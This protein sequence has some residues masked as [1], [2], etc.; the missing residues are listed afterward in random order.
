MGKQCTQIQ[1]KLFFCLFNVTQIQQKIRLFYDTVRNGS[2]E[3]NL[4]S[5]Q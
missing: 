2:A 3:L 4:N 1:T 5:V